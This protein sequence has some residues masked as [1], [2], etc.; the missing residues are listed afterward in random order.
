MV[1]AV[2]VVVVNDENKFNCLALDS[3][4]PD[5]LLA[6]LLM[7]LIRIICN[8]F[9]ACVIVCVMLHTPTHF[10]LVSSLMILPYFVAGTAEDG[11]LSVTLLGVLFF[12]FMGTCMAFYT[13]GE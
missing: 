4:Y 1:I 10:L 12:I 9:C 8:R 7:T 11:L 3:T 2:V 6:A 5:V 13:S